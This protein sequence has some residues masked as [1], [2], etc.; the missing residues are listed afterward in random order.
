MR[1]R[2]S[3]FLKS[4]KSLKIAI[5]IIGVMC[6]CLAA[7][8]ALDRLFPQPVVAAQ[9][10]TPMAQKVLPEALPNYDSV[11]VRFCLGRCEYYE[12]RS[13]VSCAPL[14]PFHAGDCRNPAHVPPAPLT[15][16]SWYGEDYAGKPTASGEIFDPSLLTASSRQHPLGARLR[17]TF[18][19]R[20]VTVRVNDRP[21]PRY[22]DRL[23][24]SRAA[25]EQ[26][27]PL[28]RGLVQATVEVLP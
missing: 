8:V 22:A 2:S 18:E 24:L 19:G 7:F 20:S 14:V 3:T 15:V 10:P 17:V 21:A 6:F 1:K 16:C 12:R 5:K 28:D 11:F 23:D 4:V 25:F 9:A 27:A 13:G 26:L